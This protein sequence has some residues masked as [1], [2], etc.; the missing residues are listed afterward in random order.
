MNPL[1]DLKWDRFYWIGDIVLPSWAGTQT[2]KGG[3]GGINSRRPSD[4]SARL[5][6]TPSDGKDRTPPT[7]AQVR[8]FEFLRDH[9]AAVT[10][11]VLWFTGAPETSATETAVIPILEGSSAG[12]AV[13]ARF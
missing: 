13:S 1:P 12:I 7:R 3:Y 10:A 4:G 8:A 9:D 6:I 2:R 11:A 5:T